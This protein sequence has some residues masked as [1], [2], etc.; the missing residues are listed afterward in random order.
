MNLFAWLRK[1]QTVRAAGTPEDAPTREE[2]APAVPSPVTGSPL[3]APTP[4][5]IRRLL[6]DAVS[7]GDESRL[8]ALCDEHRDV[9]LAHNTDWL[10]VPDAF[11][12]NPEAYAWYHD[13]LRAIARYCSESIDRTGALPPLD[14]AAAGHSH[15]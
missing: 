15:A 6:F 5:D 10:E 9:I 11:R 8:E 3:P 14:A 12:S 7:A 1:H 13:G 4:D 2:P